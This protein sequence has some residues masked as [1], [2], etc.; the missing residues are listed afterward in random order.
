VVLAANGKAAVERFEEGGLDVVLMDVQMPQMSGFE[1]TAAI[2]ALEKDRGGHIP[3]VGVTAYAMKGDRER[4]L[5][6]GMDG[7]VTKPIRSADLFA[8]IDA[9]VG[10]AVGPATA[11]APDRAEPVDRAGVLRELCGDD[12]VLA[13]QIVQVF[14]D[15]APGMLE[16][17]R[18]AV[19]GRR[20]K[21]LAQAAHKF[22][23]AAMN[24]GP[25]EAVQLCAQLERL[26]EA[27]DVARAAGLSIQVAPAVAT[28][29][30]EL[31]AATADPGDAGPAHE[32]AR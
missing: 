7:Y 26:G 18:G 1:A 21:E 23:G 29:L 28:L 4:C 22:K 12:L 19:E 25:S 14:A 16:E 15:T 10:K 27:S 24:F 17:I 2:R 31:Q 11:V 5:A 8:A 9:L 20:S 30:A 13:R 6:T 32:A 3:I